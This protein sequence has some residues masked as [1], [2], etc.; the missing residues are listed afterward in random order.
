MDDVQLS[1]L[2]ERY[3]YLVHRRCQQILRNAADAEDAFQEVFLRVRRLGAAPREGGSTLA[4]LYTIA[5]RCCFDLMERQ[6]KE[7]V[8]E[9]H[10]VTAFEARGQGSGADADQRALVAMALRQLDDK[11]RTIGVL[12]FLDGYTQEEVAA[13]TGLSRP[14]V[15]KRLQKFQERIRQLVQPAAARTP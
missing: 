13:Q 14:T 12:H 2:Y 15:A 3:G 7:P 8:A 1:Q 4:W 5:Q 11:T 10:Q 9:E 6:K